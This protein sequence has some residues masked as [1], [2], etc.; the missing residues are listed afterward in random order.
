[1]QIIKALNNN[2]ILA[3]DNTGSECICQG[4]GIG[5]NAKKGASLNVDAVERIFFPETEAESDR[6]QR[7][8]SALPEDLIELG[9]IIIA[10]ARDVYQI[11]VSDRVLLPICDHMMGAIDR[12]KK[13]I[14]LKNPM[15]DSIKEI[16]PKEFK[17]GLNAIKLIKEKYGVEMLEDEAA[18]LAYHFVIQ[19]LGR[20]ENN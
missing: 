16:Y 3:V 2:M 12:Y 19:G 17:V 18:F 7:S 9:Q 4:K 14:V 6:W 11:S 15:L 5:F 20:G 13:G 10:D 8:F 1:M